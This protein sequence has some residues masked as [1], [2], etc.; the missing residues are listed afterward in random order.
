VVALEYCH[1]TAD[2][3]FRWNIVT[4]LRMCGGAGILLLYC[5]CVVDLEICHFTVDVVVA[6]ECCHLLCRA[7]I[8]ALIGLT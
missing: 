4:L 8:G 1:F 5:G 6:L 7:K 3:W 2:V